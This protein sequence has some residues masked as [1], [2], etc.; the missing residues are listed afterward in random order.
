MD[1]E[2]FFG[3][4]LSVSYDALQKLQPEEQ[5]NYLLKKLQ[6]VNIL[7]PGTDQQQLRGL[8]QVYKFNLQAAIDYL[9]QDVYPN[10][11]FVFRAIE[12]YVE[13]SEGFSDEP[14]MGW[15]KFSSQP[16]E[17]HDVPGNHATMFAEPHVPV[18]AK[19][20]RACL[21]QVQTDD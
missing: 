8:L 7:P 15:D 11:I 1:I 2:S 5:L 6:V 13:N 21:D 10:R 20:L 16:V 18:L 9:P 14:V 12:K 19:Q 17:S 4:E 3:K